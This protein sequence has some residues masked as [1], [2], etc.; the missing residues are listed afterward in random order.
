MPST[1][2]VVDDD[3][4]IREL[5]QDNSFNVRTAG[6]GK[7]MRRALAQETPDLLILDI[8]LPGE[9]GLSL[10]RYMRQHSDTPIILLTGKDDEVDRVVGL[11]MGA[12][13]YVSKPA[14]ANCWHV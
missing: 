4:D 13:D 1:V 2:L 14:S 5:I 12:D 8:M 10:T 11:E 6:D 7:E 3:P 9:D